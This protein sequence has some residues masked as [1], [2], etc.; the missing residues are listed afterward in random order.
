[1]FILHIALTVLG[2]NEANE[3]VDFVYNFA[4]TLVLDLGAVFAPGD[5]T[6]RVVLNYGFAAL[7]DVLFGHVIVRAL[8]RP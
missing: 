8:R 4:R 7:A 3:F 6:L 2:A 5:A 1:M